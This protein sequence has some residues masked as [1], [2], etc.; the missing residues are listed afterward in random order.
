MSSTYEEYYDVAICGAGLSGLTLA[1]QLKLNYP[2]L[3][4]VMLD[5]SRFPV[6]NTT[7]KVGESSVEASGYYFCRS[8][9]LDD[10]FKNQHFKKLGLRFFTGGNKDNILERPE[11]G[12]SGFPKFDSYLYDRGVFENDLYR[13]NRQCGVDVIEEITLR[14]IQ[15]GEDDQPHHIIYKPKGE[16]EL[17]EL[18]ARWVVDAMGRKRYLQK[19]LGLALPSKRKHS[20]V[21]FRVEGRMD[22]GDLV[23]VDEVDWHFRVPNGIRYYSV[24][25]MLGEGYWI[26]IIPLATGATSIGLVASEAYH[27]FSDFDTYDKLLNWMDTHEPQVGAHLRHFPLM[28]FRKM[29]NY[30]YSSKQVLSS[31]R[32]ACTGDASVFPDPYYS[33]GGTFI[34]FNNTMIAHMIGAEMAG[35]LSQ[36][37]VDRCNSYLISQND[38]ITNTVQISYAFFNKPQVMSLSF[39]WDI[40]GGWTFVVPNLFHEMILDDRK[41]EILQSVIRSYIPLAVTMSELF[42]TWS[43][44]TANDKTF[45]HIDY[46]AL[47]F[48]K[49]I[50]QRNLQLDKTIEE[51]ADDLQRNLEDMQNLARAIFYVA[52]N[53]LDKEAFARLPETLA[54]NPTALN[55]D[56]SRWEADGLFNC[57][58]EVDLRPLLH[59]LTGLYHPKDETSISTE[60]SLKGAFDFQF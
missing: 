57:E 51:L 43:E 14:E 40:C 35:T 41:N 27:P 25:H 48:V 58:R 30:S 36:D 12:L 2:G 45:K 8:L 29:R 4:I 21:W 13:F 44:G 37:L 6:T 16:K 56:P 54:V 22:V 52:V 32:W 11:I 31:K 33:P 42:I 20:S 46:L 49:N 34:A 24:N 5:K 55:L 39:L 17:R 9:G 18:K 59:Q 53:E 15:L 23:N 38:W 28:D 7:W 50:Y 1:R 3:R 60:P 10:Y 26:W 19:K 47:P